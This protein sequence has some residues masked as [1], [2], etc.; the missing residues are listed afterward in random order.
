ML[1]ENVA[2]VLEK[3]GMRLTIF[4][5]VV[6]DKMSKCRSFRYSF[7]YVTADGANPDYSKFPLLR[8][9]SKFRMGNG[10]EFTVELAVKM[11]KK[12]N[13]CKG[14]HRTL[15]GGILGTAPVPTECTCSTRSAE[16]VIGS[17]RQRE[18]EQ[19]ANF[20]RLLQLQRTG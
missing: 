6:T 18:E 7:D 14:C 1:K 17:K 15:A 19:A 3:A 12:F 10:T 11:L 2:V 16:R 13:A 4:K 5:N 8:P 9:R 20:Q